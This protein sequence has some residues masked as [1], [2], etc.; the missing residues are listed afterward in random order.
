L[1]L[2][3]NTTPAIQFALPDAQAGA[4]HWLIPEALIPAGEYQ[5]WI[6]GDGVGTC[7]VTVTNTDPNHSSPVFIKKPRKVN[8]QMQQLF[9]GLGKQA[10]L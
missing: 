2:C 6:T 1:W 9:H 8:I 7:A 10:A 4:A 3:N 5:V